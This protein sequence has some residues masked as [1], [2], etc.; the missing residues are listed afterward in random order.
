MKLL[1][2]S[3]NLLYSLMYCVVPYANGP[4]ATSTLG[5]YLL[6]ASLLNGTHWFSTFAL[7]PS[8]WK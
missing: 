1:E 4:T 3:V 2:T 7:I 6:T 8:F 5:E